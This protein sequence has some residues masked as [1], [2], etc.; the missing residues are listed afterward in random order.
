MPLIHCRPISVCVC[1]CVSRRC[2]MASRTSTAIDQTPCSAATLKS[3]SNRS[4]SLHGS[5]LLSGGARF[6]LSLTRAH[7]TM[8]AHAWCATLRCNAS[9]TGQG[10]DQA[11]P[12]LPSSSAYTRQ[13][14]PPLHRRRSQRAAS[15]PT[16][17]LSLSLSLFDLLSQCVLALSVTDVGRSQA[18]FALLVVSASAVEFEACMR[19]RGKASLFEVALVARHVCPTHALG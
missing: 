14:R 13:L 2:W 15:I 11:A 4:Q 18:D 19:G 17:T 6:I 10:A 3:W 16:H 5:T 12:V 9:Q 7:T 8:F 1:L